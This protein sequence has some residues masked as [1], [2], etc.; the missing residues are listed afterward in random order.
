MTRSKQGI[1]GTPHIFNK[2]P[3]I[4]K[5]GAISSGFDADPPH[6]HAIIPQSF[7][8]YH[9]VPSDFQL[10]LGTKLIPSPENLS[11]H[12][13]I[14]SLL[15]SCSQKSLLKYIP[16]YKYITPP[17]RIYLQRVIL[18]QIYL[19]NCGFSMSCFCKVLKKWFADV[20]MVK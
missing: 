19:P 14:C 5:K 12:I 3:T 18:T 20:Q 17:S 2:Q 9:S 8:V 7:Q 6:P 1:F 10:R 16:L 15:S 13:Y 4:E 11:Y